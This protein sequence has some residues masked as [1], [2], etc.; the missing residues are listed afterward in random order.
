MI[1]TS[2]HCLII[3]Q[4]WS[5]FI[6]VNG[7]GRIY[8]TLTAILLTPTLH[9]TRF[10]ASSLSKPT[11]LLCFSTCIFHVF[12]GCPHFLL[13]FTSNSNAFLKTCSSSLF[14]KCPY[15]LTPFAFAISEPLFPS[16]LTSPIGPLSFFL[17]LFCTTHC[18]HLWWV[19]FS[20]RRPKS[21]AQHVII[22]TE[23]IFQTYGI[24]E[25]VCSDNG[26]PLVSVEFE[27]FFN[28]PQHRALYYKKGFLYSTG[29]KLIAKQ[30]P[31][32][33]KVIWIRFRSLNRRDWK[34]AWHFFV[35][36]Q[37][38]TTHSYWYFLLS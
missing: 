18:S 32:V 31:S 21:N 27:R 12:F 28:L 1:P 7:G 36:V 34:K 11:L 3:I 19:Q 26:H 10:K 17:H 20:L 30:N 4:F 2:N 5:G 33:L 37:D 6:P 35:T 38:N 13:P 25:T 24:P 14:N 8:P 22:C 15:H 23:A 29:H 9:L 16:I